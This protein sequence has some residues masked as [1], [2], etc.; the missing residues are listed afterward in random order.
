MTAT[1]PKKRFRFGSHIGS[2]G[3]G[4]VDKATQVD[5]DGRS[6]N[7]LFAR[8]K[9]LDKYRN[10]EEAVGRFKREVRMLDE[11]DH[12]HIINVVG[13][14]L[15]ADP[16]WFV[17]PFAES[18][19][20]KALKSGAGEDLGWVN[21]TFFAVLEAMEYAHNFSAGVLHRD[22]KPQNILIVNGVPKVS[23]FGL[24]R[25]VDPNTVDMT[26]TNIGFGTWAYVAPE[27]A[28]DASSAGPAADV[29]SLGKTLCHML[30]GVRPRPWSPDY[31]GIPEKYRT[32]I[33]RCVEHNP[34]DR[35]ANA[36]EAKDAFLVLFSELAAED[37]QVGP[38]LD[39]RELEDH[40]LVW[41]GLVDQ[42]PEVV[43]AVVDIITDFLLARTEEE[44]LFY[45]SV[46][47]LPRDL[48]THM[49]SQRPDD[50]ATIVEAY[51]GHTRGSLPFDYCDVLANFYRHVFRV[52][53]DL[54]LR[55][56]ILTRLVALGPSHNRFHVGRV[57]AGLLASIED[58]I[59]AEV[60]ASIVREDDYDAEWLANYVR[61][62]DLAQP[63]RA[64]FDAQ[65]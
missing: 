57:V 26:Q 65:E 2:G 54:A 44:E 32:F 4:A 9:L 13:R 21:E 7:H 17:M 52:S 60:A 30:T 18:D 41:E 55:E 19:A 58:D 27:Q 5:A 63:I 37:E 3:F 8:K 59:E 31:T 47:R 35:F 64:V 33:E 36:G 56:L 53:A 10:D 1:T 14:N 34:A 48:L 24:G 49:A 25:R 15:S 45:Q 40:L 38:D 61:G 62:K 43:R 51:N 46:P 50:L 39:H 12:P 11:L 20:E 42:L 28:D 23:D 16:P 29:Y 22:L 6:V